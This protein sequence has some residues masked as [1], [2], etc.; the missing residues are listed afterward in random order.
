MNNCE[1]YGFKCGHLH[2]KPRFSKY[3]QPN[4]M[5]PTYKIKVQLLKSLFHFSHIILAMIPI[6]PRLTGSAEE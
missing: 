6:T 2:N 4:T 3:L 1:M 5:F